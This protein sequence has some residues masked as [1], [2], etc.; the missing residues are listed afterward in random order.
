MRALVFENSI[1]RQAITRILSTITP[2]A[3]VGPLSPIQMRDIPAPA[4]L[5]PDWVTI[6]TQLCGVCGSDYKQ[7]FLNGSIDNPMTAMVTFPQVLGHEVV[8]RIEATG[9]AVTTRKIGDR[10]VTS[11]EGGVFPPGLPVGIVTALDHGNTRIEPYAELGQL[12]YVLLVDYGLAGGLP[13]PA[14]AGRGQNRREKSPG[15]DEKRTR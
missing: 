3:F 6:R 15:A 14:P 13:Q 2:K 4:P 8:G 5:A 12:D 11:G 10:V 7:V 9:P 1:A